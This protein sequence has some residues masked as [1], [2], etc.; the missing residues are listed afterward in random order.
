MTPDFE[1]YKQNK[2]YNC[3]VWA[4]KY[5]L[6]L[7][8]NKEYDSEILEKELNTTEDNGTSHVYILKFLCKEN[9]DFIEV[10]GNVDKLPLL[11]NYQYDGDGHYGVIVNKYEGVLEIFNPATGKIEE[12]FNHE[13]ISDWYSLR[14]GKQWGIYINKPETILIDC[15]ATGKTIS[16]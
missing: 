10:T 16:R 8:L 3:G 15:D 6:K 1:Y 9:I 11:I 7:V 14:Y 2:D 13:F 4:L 5:I 12:I